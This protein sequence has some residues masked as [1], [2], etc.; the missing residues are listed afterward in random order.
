MTEIKKWYSAGD[1]DAAE[2]TDEA[3]LGGGLRRSPIELRTR[4]QLAKPQIKLG[5]SWRVE[6]AFYGTSSG[7]V[8]GGDNRKRILMDGLH[9]A[10][11]KLSQGLIARAGVSHR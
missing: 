2:G 4:Q 8:H 10:V 1:E 9:L 3:G 7:G 5:I 11:G 6:D